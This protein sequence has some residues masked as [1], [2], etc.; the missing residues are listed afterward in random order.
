[1]GFGTIGRGYQGVATILGHQGGLTTSL[2][3]IRNISSS[4]TSCNAISE[5]FRLRRAVFISDIHNFLHETSFVLHTHEYKI[6][7][8]TPNPFSP[9]SLQLYK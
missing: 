5:N 8:P 6:Y 4:G 9:L 1:M 3:L 2:L 7:L